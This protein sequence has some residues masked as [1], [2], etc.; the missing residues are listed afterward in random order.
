VVPH[1]PTIPKAEDQNLFVNEQMPFPSNFNN[2]SQNYPSY[3]YN[4][5]SRWDADSTLTDSLRLF[6]FQ[7]LAALE[8]NVD[9]L[10]DVLDIKG[11][12]DNTMI[13]FTSDNGYMKGEHLLDGKQIPYEESIRVPLFIRYP[14]WFN[15]STVIDD[16]MASNIDLAPTI[17]EAAGI[18]DTFGMDGISL[19]QLAMHSIHRKNFL[20]EYGGLGGVPAIRTVRSL[21]YKYN[22]DYCN[23]VTEEFFDLVNDPLENNNLINTSSYVALIQTYRDTL[24]SLRLQFTDTDPINITCSLTNQ[25]YSRA[26]DEEENMPQFKFIFPNPADEMV[27]FNFLNR[28]NVTSFISIKN[29]LGATMLNKTIFGDGWNSFK[30]DCSNWIAGMYFVNVINEVEVLKGKFIVEHH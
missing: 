7:C 17:L 12:L 14:K 6:E 3:L 13:I 4:N 25:V 18:E 23:A 28:K 29:E 9:T 10:I 27:E 5:G 19:H 2:Y 24:A 16:E 22:Y 15:D 8:D 21:Q 26:A 30:I 11:I 20:Y 1:G